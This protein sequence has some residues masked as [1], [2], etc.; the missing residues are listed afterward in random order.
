M[1]NA[2]ALRSFLAAA[3]IWAASALPGLAQTAPNWTY[4]YVPT[5]AQWNSI[6]AGKQDYLGAPPLLTTGGTMTGRLITSA[7][8]TARAGINLPAG[9]PP[10]SPIDGDFW[11]TAA[12]SFIRINGAT[13]GP[14]SGASSSSFA[15]TAP[16]AV[17]FPAGVTTY[18]VTVDS[19][20]T[21]ASQLGINLSN[22]NSWL[23]TQTFPANS[24]TFAEFPTIGANTVIGSIAGGNP[25]A[26]TTTQLTTL[27]NPFTAALSGSV[28]APVTA[29]GKFLRDDNSWQVVA[30]TGTVT[31]LTA[32]TAITFSSGATCVTT[33]TIN[34]AGVTSNVAGT[35]I[36]VSG[37]TG[38]VTVSLISPVTAATGGTGVASPATHTIPINQGASAQANTGTGTTGQCVVSNGASADP[39]FISGCRVLLLT[40]TAAGTPASLASTNIFTSAY[41]EYE[42]VFEGLLPTTTLATGLLKVNSGGVQSTSYLASQN[43]A[44]NGTFSGGALT[45][46]LV[47]T[48]TTS[49]VNTGPGLNGWIR[50]HNPSGTAAPKM[51]TGQTNWNNSTP[52]NG[53]SW[54]SGYWN[55]NAAVT[56]FE[57]TFSTGTIING[58][59]I[60][61]Y[62]FL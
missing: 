3:L 51:W 14:I 56:G 24:L 26:L 61:V 59:V 23:A 7:S 49:Q 45:T 34:N 42:L 37:A 19:T 31:T 4:G 39:G 33:C 10:T 35:G 22:A 25:A 62:G 48:G 30:G 36:Q 11:T 2:R 58:G 40:L 5:Q 38:A 28:N 57:F 12:G 29:T 53:L 9:V 15:A 60:K 52:A 32:G 41:N 1:T 47:L 50:V 27:V 16:L 44:T 8:T 17:S 18:A 20:L 55:N 21:A 6:F 13:I 46:S 54:P 43:Q